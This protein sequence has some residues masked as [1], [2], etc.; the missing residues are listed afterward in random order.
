AT[1]TRMTRTPTMNANSD[2]DYIDAKVEAARAG[3]DGRL[4][5]FEANVNSRFAEM[6]AK[7]DKSV[8]ELN[9]KIDTV[10][11]ELNAKIDKLGAELRKEIAEVGARMVQWMVS[12]FLASMAIFITVMTFV[13]NNAVPKAA[14]ATPPVIIQLSPQGVTLPAPAAPAVNPRP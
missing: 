14:P 8:A 13:L 12:I 2:K 6:N 1:K 11:A 7:F 5:A 4:D 3:M 10:A 9:A